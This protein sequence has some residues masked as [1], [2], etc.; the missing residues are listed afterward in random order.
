MN[1]GPLARFAFYMK[2]LMLFAMVGVAAVPHVADAQSIGDRLK[3]KVVDRANAKADEAMEK[4][5]NKLEQTVNC[6][7]SDSDCIAEAKKEKKEVKTF[8]TDAE[9]EKANEEREAA[10]EKAK[11]DVEASKAQPSDAGGAAPAASAGGA[12]AGAASARP[13]DAA[14]ANFDFVPGER[15]LFADDFSKDRVGNFPQRLRLVEGNV[16]VV[17]SKGVRWIQSTSVPAIIAIDLP[18]TLPRRFTM[19]F[20]LTLASFPTTIGTQQNDEAGANPDTLFTYAHIGAFS[21]GLMGGGVKTDTPT[22]IGGQSR[23][24]LVGVAAKGR[25]QADGDYVKV[26]VNETRVAN[27][28][29]TKFGRDRTL[30]VALFGSSEAPAMFG[31]ITVAA[32]GRELYDALLADGRVAT[33]GILF[34]TGSDRIRPESGPTLKQIGDMLKEHGDLKLLIEGHTDNVGN[35]ASNLSL[36]D[37]RAAAVKAFLVDTYGITGARLTTKGLGDTKPSTAN[38]TAEG[39]QQNRRVEL[40][41]IP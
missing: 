1:A 7:A 26:Y 6:L 13:G 5:L 14:W 25:I 32:G 23:E 12:A 39:R 10:I 15:V 8:K 3:A 36:S 34:D 4:A 24:G 40:V 21:S 35:A 38:T 18:E 19:E 41:K 9:L 11:A 2:A 31:N 22:D 29:S 20:D 27:V 33:Q 16:Q 30:Y 37:K 28:P 17:E